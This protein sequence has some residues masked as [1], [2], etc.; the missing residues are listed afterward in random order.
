MRKQCKKL[1]LHKLLLPSKPL[2][3]FDI[4]KKP[5]LFFSDMPVFYYFCRH[6]GSCQLFFRTMRE[7]MIRLLK[8]F[9][10]TTA[11]LV[12]IW[13]ACLVPVPETP[14]SQV[15]M[16]DKWTHFVMFGGLCAV[17]W[18]EYLR[19]KDEGKN[20]K[21]KLSKHED[22]KKESPAVDLGLSLLHFSVVSFFFAWLTGGLIELAQAY[23]TNGLR[24]GE[25]LDFAADGIGS[26]LGQP[27]GILLARCGAKW[28]KAP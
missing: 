9:P 23:L 10:L 7:E 18:W 5:L 3:F 15:S 14:L 4:N 8:C 21:M 6:S 1:I 25:W 11:A 13:I 19:G 26:L 28:R 27:I 16:I 20:E 24:S 22:T 2:F 17:M 12:V